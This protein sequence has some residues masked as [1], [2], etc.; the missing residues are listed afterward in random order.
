M[1]IFSLLRLSFYTMC[2]LQ[3]FQ[4]LASK[5]AFAFS[6]ICLAQYER[7][8]LLSLVFLASRHLFK[9]FFMCD[10]YALH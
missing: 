4:F 8:A 2:S 3:F 9:L 10:W 7:V 5:N 6:S 1:L